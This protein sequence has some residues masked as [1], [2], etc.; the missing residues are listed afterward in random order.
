MRA[1]LTGGNG[2]V[3]RHLADHLRREG[4]EVTILDLPDDITD[5]GVVEKVLREARPDAIYHLAA[6]SHVGS[7]WSDPSTVLRVNVIGSAVVFA[8]A[9]EV[10]PEATTLFV[11][12]AEVYG[13]VQ[14]DRLPLDEDC[15]PA[16][17]SPYA[18]SKLAGEILAQQ[19]VRAFGQRIVIARPFNHVGPGQSPQFFVPAMASRMVDAVRDGRREIPVG[20]LTTRRDFLDVRDVVSAYRLLVEHGV[21]GEVYNIASG[22]DRSMSDI[23]YEIRSLVDDSLT[24][25]ADETLMRPVDVPVLRGNAKKI[26]AATGWSPR[27]SWSDTL[28]DVIASVR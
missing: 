14:P 26:N 18:A 9:R 5:G 16:P 4:D 19:A 13:A 22:V 8:V 7:S 10:V 17:I 15:T 20:N 3:G 24:L 21:A 1:L 6:L 12:S 23:A 25:V 2:F 11:S 28:A 27:W